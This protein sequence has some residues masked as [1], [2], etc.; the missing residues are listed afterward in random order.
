MWFCNSLKLP[1]NEYQQ[2]ID[3]TLIGDFEK[4]ITAYLKAFLA[5]IVNVVLDISISFIPN[6]IFYVSK[7]KILN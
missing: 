4:I 1:H 7:M 2:R 6:N 5:N 3:I